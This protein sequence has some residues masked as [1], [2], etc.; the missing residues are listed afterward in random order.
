MKPDAKKKLIAACVALA[1]AAIGGLGYEWQD[2][3][4]ARKSFKADLVAQGLELQE[5]RIALRAC[6]RSG[7][8][9]LGA[10]L[11]DGLRSLLPG[12]LVE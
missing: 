2:E 7:D 3:K 10:K 11:R 12:F 5:A 4:G 6:I 1:M 8:N 9:D